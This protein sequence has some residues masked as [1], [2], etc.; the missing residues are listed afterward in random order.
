MASRRFSQGCKSPAAE[1][2]QGVRGQARSHGTAEEQGEEQEEEQ[3]EK[4]GEEQEE[5]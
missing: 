4:Q 3:E 1:P 2:G 5:E